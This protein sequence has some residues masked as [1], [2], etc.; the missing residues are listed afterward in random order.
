[1]KGYG[2][3]LIMGNLTADP[4]KREINSSDGEPL[5]KVEFSVAVKER[6][7]DEPQFLRCE[8]WNKLGDI[9]MMAKKGEPIFIEAKIDQH[10]YKDKEGNN[11]T[12]TKYRAREFRFLGSKQQ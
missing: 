3:A 9:V 1:M 5:S 2:K 12:I 6:E 7:E 11:R 4:E 8:A 10:N